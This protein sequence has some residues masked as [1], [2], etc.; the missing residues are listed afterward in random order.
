LVYSK[1]KEEHADHLRVVLKTLEEHKLY[2][3]VEKSEF[4][5]KKVHVL[6]HVVSEKGISVDLAKVEV[7]VSWPRPTNV[8]K[9]RSFLGM[10]SYY[11]R[12]AGGFY[13]LA[14]PITKLLRKSN[15]FEWT[16]EC[17][18]SFQELKK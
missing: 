13:K 3:E 12:F 6:G 14:M 9:V 16:K 18:N 11:R 7:I 17:E 8:S 5:L 2:A 1:T 4:W 10:A 15:K